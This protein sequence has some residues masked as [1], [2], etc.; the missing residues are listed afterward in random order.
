M[1]EDKFNFIKIKNNRNKNLVTMIDKT[2][3]KL[4]NANKLVNKIAEKKIGKNDAIKAYNNL[5]DATEQ[6]SK[7]RSTE[8]RQ[9]MVE[10]FNYLGEIFNGPTG[11]ESDSRGEAL[12]ILT[13]NQMLSRFS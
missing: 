9:K 7:F 6:I 5:V 13:P 8:P 3:Y 1:S 4:N 10:I 2:R 11:E 12:K